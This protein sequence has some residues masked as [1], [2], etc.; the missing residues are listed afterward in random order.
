MYIISYIC[1][2]EIACGK[3]IMYYPRIA[4]YIG[5]YIA[6]FVDIGYN[7]KYPGTCL[8]Y[9]VSVRLYVK[10]HKIA[11]LKHDFNNNTNDNNA[12]NKE[13]SALHR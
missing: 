6:T 1:T 3:Y 11:Y 13:F 4:C 8:A 10:L 12:N 9:I 7:R 2:N 5:A